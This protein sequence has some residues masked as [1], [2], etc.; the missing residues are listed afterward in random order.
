MH[1]RPAET[2]LNRESNHMTIYLLDTFW[3]SKWMREFCGF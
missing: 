1:G 3:H 2:G